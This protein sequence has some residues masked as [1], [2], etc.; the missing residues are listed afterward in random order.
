MTV[1]SGSGLV[2]VELGYLYVL[3]T[4]LF[5]RNH[6]LISSLPRGIRE[7]VHWWYTLLPV[8]SVLTLRRVRVNWADLVGFHGQRRKLWVRAVRI[9]SAQGALVDN[10]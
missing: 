3:L 2:L 7:R 1:L 8:S 4:M 5:W 9:A 6:R 10:S